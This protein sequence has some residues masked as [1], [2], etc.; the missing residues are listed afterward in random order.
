MKRNPNKYVTVIPDPHSGARLG[1]KLKDIVTAFILAEWFNLQYLHNPIPDYGDGNDWESF[2]GLGENEPLF[3]DVV[4]KNILTV[5]YS[6]LLGIQRLRYKSY[7]LLRNIIKIEIIFRRII[8]TRLDRIKFME[9]WRSPYWH[10]IQFNYI[11]EVFRDIN[12]NNHEIIYCFLH[13][14]RVTL[15][16]INV[17]G[18][19]KIIDPTIYKNVLNILRKKY[20]Q[21]QHPDKTCYYNPDT[22]NIAVPIRREDATIKNERFITLKFYENIVE[23]LIEIFADKSYELHI[24]SLASQEDAQEI[25]NSFSQKDERVKFHIN[26]A[27]MKV[28]HHLIVSDVLIVDHSSFHH[29]AGFWSQ[30]IKLYHPYGY[31]KELNDDSWIPLDDDGIFNKNNFLDAVKNCQNRL[32]NLI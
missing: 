32:S 5:S 24:Y 27:S 29:I 25:I 1:H 11:Q 2:W 19:E 7:F 3:T 13:G 23:Q 15:T 16:Q 20:H 31:I 26:E 8:Y 4:K 22:I 28:M 12:D 17:W 18:K 9:E 30:N 21:K 10:G 14:V 6:P